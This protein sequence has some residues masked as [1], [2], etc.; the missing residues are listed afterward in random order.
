MTHQS[1]TFRM[2]QTAIAS[3]FLVCTLLASPGAR[4]QYYE[5]WVVQ[6]ANLPTDSQIADCVRAIV[7][8]IAKPKEQKAWNAQTQQELAD[9]NDKYVVIS[10]EA[11][12][13]KQAR[14]DDNLFLR[15]TTDLGKANKAPAQLTLTRSNDQTVGVARAALIHVNAEGLANAFSLDKKR[16]KF[17]YGVGIHRD[18][19]DA[20][21]RIFTTDLR[22]GYRHGFH[23]RQ[24]DTAGV[25]QV[26]WISLTRLNNHIANTAQLQTEVGYDWSRR[27]FEADKYDRILFDRQVNIK[28]NP[29]SDRTIKDPAGLKPTTTGVGVGLDFTWYQPTDVKWIPKASKQYLPDSW[30]FST[31]RNVGTGSAKQY[32]TLNKLSFTWDLARSATAGLQPSLSLAREVGSNF[33]EGITPAA[34]TLLT[35]DVKYN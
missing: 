4:A 13:I 1:T 33:R 25:E 10:K 5:A 6:C 3:S 30:N 23:V 24:E 12:A 34:K 29:F 26:G 27:W 9:A 21:K 8:G 20:A 7:A 2:S 15:K 32:S 22:L 35:L 17:Y 18:D 19:T 28:I 16:Q 11:K 31:L 14:A